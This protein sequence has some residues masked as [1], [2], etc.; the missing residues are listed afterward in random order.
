MSDRRINGRTYEEFMQAVDRE[1]VKRIGLSHED[2]P[3]TD[4]Y[5]Y[6]LDEL[7]P[8][9]AAR[10]ILHDAGD[11]LGYDEDEMDRLALFDAEDR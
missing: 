10:Y 2:L 8:E 7:S 3:D 5:S 11:Q 1:L 4:S 9:E 6:F